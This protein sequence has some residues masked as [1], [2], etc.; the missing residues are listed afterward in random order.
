MDAGCSRLPTNARPS[1]PRFALPAFFLAK[2]SAH[3]PQAVA[4][5]AFGAREPTSPMR[6]F[7]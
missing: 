6:Y 7:S 2:I 1:T 5:L 4:L 3:L